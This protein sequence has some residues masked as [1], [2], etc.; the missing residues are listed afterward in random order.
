MVRLFGSVEEGGRVWHKTYGADFIEKSYET[1]KEIADFASDPFLK[2]VVVNEAVVGTAEGFSQLKLLRPDIL[3]IAGEPHEYEALQKVCDLIL[4]TDY[5][6][7]GYLIIHAAKEL[8]ARQF[9]HISFPRHLEFTWITRRRDIMRAACEDLGL[10]FYELT[11]L[12]PTEVGQDLAAQSI[13]TSFPSW[14]KEYGNETVFFST[15]DAH[16]EPLIWS[17]ANKGGYFLEADNASPTLG[18]P[19]VFQLD[20]ADYSSRSSDFLVELERRVLEKGASGRLGTWIYS[21]AYCR[22]AGA[23]EFGRMV[24]NGQV[25]LEDTGAILMA[26]GKFSPGA[27][28]NGSYYTDEFTGKPVRN[29]FLIYQDTYIFGEGFM[30]LTS[31]E[32]PL[33][34]LVLGTALEDGRGEESLNNDFEHLAFA[35]LKIAPWE[36]DK[37]WRED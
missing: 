11:A 23:L 16:T 36:P 17:V 27:D 21:A 18:Y 33:K 3:L 4:F 12:D 8:G 5:V 25:R 22:S 15:N 14:L 1:S 10:E 30:Q 9:A 13:L 29:L 32:V 28:W 24:V 31:L 35:R 19:G 26:L 2:V 6:A 34:Y 20:P 37:A 7:R